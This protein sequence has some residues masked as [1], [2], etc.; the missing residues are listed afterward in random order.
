MSFVYR[1]VDEDGAVRY[2][3]KVSG[4]TA[5]RLKRRIGEH[6]ND[7][8]FDPCW[9]VEYIGDLT[10]ADADI[11][12]T[13]LI[14]RYPQE[15]LINRAKRWGA[16]EISLAAIP[17][18]VPYDSENIA[19][20]KGSFPTKQEPLACDVNKT[21]PVQSFRSTPSS[22]LRAYPLYVSIKEATAMTGLSAYFLRNSVRTGT[23]PHI[24]SGGKS[25]GT[26]KIPVSALLA[27]GPDVW[28]NKE[29]MGDGDV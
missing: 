13:W 5:M 1:Y 9:R 19:T 21:Q 25:T 20:I 15:P 16:S 11:L 28:P 2:V 27:M 26:I 24:R 10:D 29:V 22:V 12:E 3:G 17:P 7:E 23:I 8:A 14:A 18:F 4:V 6:A